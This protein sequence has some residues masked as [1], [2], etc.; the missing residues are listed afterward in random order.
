M[1]RL[2]SALTT[3]IVILVGFAT[4]L[5]LL[6]TGDLGLFS[7]ATG[8][9]GLPAL[10]VSL[11][12]IVSI[13]I[14]LTVLIGI[15]NL[16]SVHV[17]RMTR[18]ERGWP[19]SLILLISTLA[20]LVIGVL[21]RNGAVDPQVPL[22]LQNLQLSIESALAGLV[23]FALVYGVFRMMRSRVTWS[24]FLFTLVLL[25][26]LVGALPIAGAGFSL[27]GLVRDWFLSVPVSAGVRG[28][29]LG[30]VLASVVAGIRILIGQDRSYRE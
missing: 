18:R 3:A 8:A 14:A 10:A 12:R 1:A 15:L 27:L 28:I 24:A 6:S 25:A 2:G 11:V 21:G 4:L 20:A 7:T 26:L 5:G 29:L 17:L 13:T 19:Y 22:L 9:I 30:I 16:I 23:L